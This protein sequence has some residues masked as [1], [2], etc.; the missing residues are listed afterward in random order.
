[1]KYVLCLIFSENMKETLLMLKKN[2]PYPD[3]LN[4]PGGKIEE[5]ENANHA[6]IREVKEETN[7]DTPFIEYMMKISYPSGTLMSIYY[8]RLLDQKKFNINYESEEG[9]LNWYNVSQ[10][11]DIT[12]PIFAGEGNL[13]YFINYAIKLEEIRCQQNS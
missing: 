2:G 4:A 11:L 9:R 7:I 3:C 1:M 6:C 8:T 10:C 12:N 5:G 13:A